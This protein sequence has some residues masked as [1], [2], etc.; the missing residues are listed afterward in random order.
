MFVLQRILVLS[1]VLSLGAAVMAFSD[2]PRGFIGDTGSGW[3]STS[4][5][6]VR[7]GNEH[8]GGS[9]LAVD[10]INGTGINAAGEVHDQDPMSMWLSLEFT[11]PDRFGVS[12]GGHWIE[13]AFDQ[14]YSV[15]ELWIWNYTEGDPGGYAWSA[16]GLRNVTIKYTSVDG[17]GGWGSLAPGDW[18]TVFSG[19]LDVYDPGQPRT[20]SDVIDFGSASVKYVL[21]TT[22]TDDTTMNWVA[23][24]RPINYPNDDSGLSE[25]RFYA[26]DPP[27][28]P[29]APPL[30][31]LEFDTVTSLTFQSMIGSTYSLE[32][33][34][35]GLPMDWMPAGQEVDGDGGIMKMRD[36]AGYSALNL[37]RVRKL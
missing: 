22:S 23:E 32:R 25:V 3:N 7:A 13:Y 4:A 35:T 33:N 31:G 30:L 17:P 37:Y 10:T 11:T 12:P 15:Q 14:V 36:P 1:T 5:V 20:T 6:S 16:Q 21:I 18:T 24:H 26:T 27:A 2:A 9:R 8:A 34:L 28:P 29:A 19:D